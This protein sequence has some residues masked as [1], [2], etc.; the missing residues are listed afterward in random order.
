MGS[1]GRRAGAAPIAGHPRSTRRR[2]AM[3]S[4][5]LILEAFDPVAERSLLDIGCGSGTLARA[6]AARGATV[7]GIDPNPAAVAA[8]RHAV[9][10]G[11]FAV[12]GAEAL[13][14]AS[15]SFDGAIVLNALHH[16]PDAPAALA[17]A[18]RIVRPGAAILVI[19]PLAEGSYF[20]ALRLIEDE[21]T[22]R[23]A[24]QAALAAAIAAGRFACQRDIT[25][26]RRESFA[27]VDEF[28]R[29][30]LAVDP[31][32]AEAVR[33]RRAQIEAILSDVAESD[34]ERGF[35]L[36]QPLRAQVLRNRP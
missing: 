24:A 5:A 14:F 20:T 32:R 7:T 8:A 3:D 15:A 30:V 34:P 26:A 28:L 18:A 27:S 21:I 4:L 29:R 25:F 6:L 10:T 11:R 2:Q 16:V 12:A 22:V 31:A 33:D 9:P 19:E 1:A 23:R 13:P 17:E 36:V 35:A